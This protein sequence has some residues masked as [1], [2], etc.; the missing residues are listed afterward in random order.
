MIIDFPPLCDVSS[1]LT[2]R[3]NNIISRS[4]WNGDYYIDG[5]NNVVLLYTNKES[6]HTTHSREILSFRDPFHPITRN[7]F[8]DGY[9]CR[10]EQSPWLYIPSLSIRLSCQVSFIS[11]EKISFL[12]YPVEICWCWMER[13]PDVQLRWLHG[14]VMLLLP[15]GGN[16]N[17]PN[18]EYK[19]IDGTN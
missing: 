4:T 9:I 15:P 6:Q 8:W 10:M 1:L 19:D 7:I 2:I 3:D 17:E 11:I 14:F 13:S 5:T 12:H 16:D 18:T